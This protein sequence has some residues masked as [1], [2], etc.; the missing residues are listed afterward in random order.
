[1]GQEQLID[2]WRV[3]RVVSHEKRLQ[4]LW[5]LF[6]NGEQCVRELMVEAEMSRPNASIQL[7]TLYLAGLIR[8]RRQDMN[9]I[10]RAEADL[11]VECATPLL[12][13]L[14]KCSEECISFES[15]VHQVT[16][17]THERRIEIIRLLQD[18]PLP[19]VRLE[20]LSGMTSSALSRHL[21]KLE[22]R[23]VVR[24]DG[25]LYCI[26]PPREPLGAVLLEIVCRKESS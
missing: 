2:L 15:V 23:K 25:E 12:E 24:W 6:E 4:L 5:L 18:G 21:L 22:A 17:F 1:M 7:K 19:F 13:A 11:R 16:A 8:F 9:V 3:C 10:Y 26:A 14:R 20:G